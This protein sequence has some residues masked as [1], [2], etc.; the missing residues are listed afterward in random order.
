[1][2]ASSRGRHERES[3]SQ[4]AFVGVRFEGS[5]ASASLMFASERPTRWAAAMNAM[6]R[7]MSE[8]KRRCFPGSRVDQMSPCDS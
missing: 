7:S 1:M 3:A 2:R 5:V 6:R 8:L 4:S